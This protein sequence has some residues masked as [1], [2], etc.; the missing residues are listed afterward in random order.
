MEGHSEEEAR[1]LIKGLLTDMKTRLVCSGIQNHA[2]FA[3][4]NW[5]NLLNGMFMLEREDPVIII[6]P[7][8]FSHAPSY[9]S[10]V[11]S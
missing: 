9:S 1:D 10:S 6:D 8:P 3:L 7:I 11:W 4:M 2:F 5:D